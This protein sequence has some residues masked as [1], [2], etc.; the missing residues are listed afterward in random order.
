MFRSATYALISAA[1]RKKLDSHSAK[2]ILL[3]YDEDAGN[4]VYRIYDL[5]SK[6]VFCSRDVI[7]DEMGTSTEKKDENTVVDISKN[8][9]YV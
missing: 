1:K 3:G 4:K 7:I 8:I 6:R 2:C 9:T 5:A